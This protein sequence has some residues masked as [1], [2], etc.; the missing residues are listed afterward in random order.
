MSHNLQSAPHQQA[1]DVVPD[2]DTLGKG[3]PLGCIPGALYSSVAIGGVIATGYRLLSSGPSVSTLSEPRLQLA[4]VAS[5]FW[6]FSWAEGRYVRTY[7]WWSA[8]LDT[9]VV[10]LAFIAFYG[11]GST[12]GEAWLFR[13]GTLCIAMSVAV[14]LSWFDAVGRTKD[15]T[16]SRFMMH[17]TAYVTALA[18]IHFESDTVLRPLALGVVFTLTVASGVPPLMKRVRA[19]AIAQAAQLVTRFI[20]FF[21][22]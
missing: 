16:V 19:Y 13:V 21:R 1:R 3:H 10:G 17:S 4:I 18:A 12:N 2:E 7:G 6:A 5:T 22:W 9:I 20:N 14:Q 15:L 8:S 11:V